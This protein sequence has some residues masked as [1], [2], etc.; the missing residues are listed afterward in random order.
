MDRLSIEDVFGTQTER[1]VDTLLPGGRRGPLPYW[2]LLPIAVALGFSGYAQASAGNA[3]MGLAEKIALGLALAA[4]CFIGGWFEDELFRRMRRLDRIAR[5]AVSTIAGTSVGLVGANLLQV[6]GSL[7]GV[8][9]RAMWL[10]L[11]GAFWFVGAS[12]G[13]LLM[14]ILDGM[15]GAVIGDFRRRIVLTIVGLMIFAF[16]AGDLVAL[17]CID[18]LTAHPATKDTVWMP[19]FFGF[20]LASVPFLIQLRNNPSWVV[21]SAFGATVVIVLPAVLSVIA[22]LAE[23]VMER[24]TLIQSAF[25]R[26]ADGDRSVHVEEAG[27]P[28]FFSLALSFNEMVD[29]LYLAERI[30]RAFGQYVSAQVLERIRAQ[31]GSVFLPAQLRTATVFFADIRGFTPISER[32]QPSVVVDMLNR[33]LEQIVPVVEQHQGFLNKFIGDAVVVVF[34]GPIEQRDHAERAVRCA[35]ALQRL[36]TQLN[37]HGFFPEVGDLEIGIGIA[38]GP[39]LCGNIGTRSRVEYTVIGDTVNLSSRMTGH[40]RSGEV[41]VSEETAKRLPKDTPA[42]ASAPIKFKGKDRSLTP[43]R[44]WPANALDLSGR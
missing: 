9:E 43:Y 1:V 8:G 30:E 2:A 44:V 29:R 34:N 12:I 39:M 22:K 11:M 10:L 6:A 28:E 32:L 14:V 33:Y 20:D 21:A 27:S 35:V 38:T 15:L 31:Q 37:A 26:I 19:T 40:A 18:W 16:A 42:F 4:A 17:A 13:T 36:M 41:W 24:I 3:P 23:T 5:F 7:H 25:E